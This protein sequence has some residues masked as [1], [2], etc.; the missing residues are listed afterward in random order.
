MSCFEKINTDASLRVY[1]EARSIIKQV[2]SAFTPRQ[3]QLN[4]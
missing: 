1:L 2:L 4:N 3:R